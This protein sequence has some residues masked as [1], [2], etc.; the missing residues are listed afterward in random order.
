MAIAVQLAAIAKKALEILASN[1]KGR[2]FLGYA[3]GIA[4]FIILLPVIALVGLFGWMSGMD[5]SVAD[6]G[7]IL[8]GLTADQ[9]EQVSAIASVYNSI[10]VAF[11]EKGLSQKDIE[12]A[13]ALFLAYLVSKEPDDEM[14]QDLAGC[15]T[16][17]SGTVSV[18]DLFELKFGVTVTDEERRYF[19]ERHGV[20]GAGEAGDTGC[21]LEKWECDV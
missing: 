21:E 3:V 2:K 17:I 15:F 20:T 18:Y 6:A 14:C 10:P 12:K 13:E 1:E 16:D 5:G 19:D 7:Q 11:S 8:S 4:I 9:Q